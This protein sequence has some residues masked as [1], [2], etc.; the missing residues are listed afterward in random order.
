ML[1][2]SNSNNTFLTAETD[3]GL[4][5]L[6][7]VPATEL[8]VVSPV[9][10]LFALAMVQLGAKGE[11]RTQ[12]NKLLSGDGNDEEVSD[13][14]ASLS[15]HIHEATNDVK[16]YIANGFF[17]DKKF[18]IEEQYR[19]NIVK[20]YSAAIESLD[21]ENNAT[22][23]A[24]VINTFVS[25]ATAEKL[26]NIINADNIE[27]AFSVLVNAVYF[28]AEWRNKFHPDKSSNS[29]FYSRPDREREIMF[30]GDF[31]VYRLYAEDED[32]QV[33]SMPYTDES[34]ALNIF[35]PKQKFALDGIRANITGEKVQ[36]LLSDLS[37]TKLSI[38]IP[39]MRIENDYKLKEALIDMGATEMFSPNSDL[40]GITSTAPLRV[41]DAA[42]KALIEVDENGT[43]AAA[44]TTMVMLAGSTMEQ[45]KQFFADHPFMF[46]LTKNKHPLFMGQ[47]A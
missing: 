3:F 29:K 9:S 7:Q 2:T 10:V 22:D 27:G 24:E 42:H 45:P 37:S 23:S 12:I 8:L 4:N 19:S 15:G 36:Q 30:M 16:A 11:T 25:N 38:R 40:S 20:S 21:L 35:L 28:K 46:I 31:G 5:L 44:A 32:M 26:E 1:T 43:T 47:F 17:L 33:L 18:D 13:Y 34:F 39:K 6:R 14:Y 41:S